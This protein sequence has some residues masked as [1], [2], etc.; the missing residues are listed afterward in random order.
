ML[1]GERIIARGKISG[2]AYIGPSLLLILGLA[3][4][5]VGVGIILIIVAIVEIVRLLNVEIGVTNRRVIGKV[6]VISTHSLDL[7]LAQLEGVSVSRGL[8]GAIF[9]FGAITVSGTG[10]TRMR[11]PGIADPER[12]RRSF[13]G[14]A[15]ACVAN[16]AVESKPA[17]SMQGNQSSAAS[18]A[19]F[20]VQVVDR[21][22][23]EENWIEVTA[24]NEQQAL[25]KATNTGAI[26]GQCRLMSID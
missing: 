15:D 12:L 18:S 2:A 24:I 13:L 1:K 7:R 9:R 3:T 22:S 23:G 5:I 8:F 10:Q 21:K 17:T 26:V 4:A 25:Q 20:Q 14:A 6:G 16:P 19:K 11:F